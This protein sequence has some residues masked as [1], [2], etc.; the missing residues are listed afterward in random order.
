MRAN[1]Q[2]IDTQQNTQCIAVHTAIETARKFLE[3]YYS[4]VVFKYV[5]FNEKSLVIVM[6]IGIMLE[7]NKGARQAI[8]TARKFLEQY[9][10]PVIYKSAYLEGK[11]WIVTMDVGLVYERIVKVH[12]DS[13]SGKISGYA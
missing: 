3:Q 9:N 6:D 10:S 2:T 8:D 11:T 5:I 1:Y 12:I 13:E 7:K 4:P